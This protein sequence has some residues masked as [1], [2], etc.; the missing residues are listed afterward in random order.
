MNRLLYD[1]WIQLKSAAE[2]VCR[3]KQE[4]YILELFKLGKDMEKV[5]FL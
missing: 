3:L 1:Q 4:R 2:Q 5:K